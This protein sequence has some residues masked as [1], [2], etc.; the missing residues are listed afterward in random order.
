MSEDDGIV[1]TT[2]NFTR[3]NTISEFLAVF[4]V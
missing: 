3:E 2:G 4:Y 1:K